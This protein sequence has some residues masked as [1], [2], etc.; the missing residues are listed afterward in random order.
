M[1][2]STTHFFLPPV[3]CGAFGALAPYVY[4]IRGKSG[5]S[6]DFLCPHEP[7]HSGGIAPKSGL[8]RPFSHFFWTT[9]VFTVVFTY[10]VTSV[11]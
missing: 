11:K 7:G 10:N 1:T 5:V 3:F 2:N 6:E 9:Y 8:F 4:T